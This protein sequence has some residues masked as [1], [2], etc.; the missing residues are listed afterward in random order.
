MNGQSSVLL[1]AGCGHRIGQRHPASLWHHAKEILIHALDA[2]GDW[3]E[4]AAERHRLMTLDERAL[5]DL[6]LNRDSVD[7]EASKPFW[8]V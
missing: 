3:Q 7:A 6:G 4:R 2:V 5:G 8:R 1:N